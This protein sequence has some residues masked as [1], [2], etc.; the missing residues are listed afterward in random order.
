MNSLATGPDWLAKMLAAGDLVLLDGAMGTELQARGVPMDGRAW[1]GAAALTHPQVCR[2]IHA[3][4]IRA[5][6][7]VIIANTFSAGRHI[8]APAGFG[9]QVAKINRQ[10]VAMA[11]EA[12]EEAADHPVAVAGSAS[13]CRP[14]DPLGRRRTSLRRRL[15]NRRISWRRRVWISSPSRCVSAKI[16]P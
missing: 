16:I 4:Y 7:D 13:G 12:R 8:L 2:D 6:A 15:A 1:S 10:A 14:A 5:G 9:D 11:L 3:D